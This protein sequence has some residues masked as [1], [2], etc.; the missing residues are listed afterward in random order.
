MVEAEA[1]ALA[2]V[3]DALG[4]AVEVKLRPLANA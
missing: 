1:A 3:T 4:V 2:A